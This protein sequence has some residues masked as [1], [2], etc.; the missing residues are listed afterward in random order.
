LEVNIIAQC[1]FIVDL[2]FDIVDYRLN[3]DRRVGLGT[4]WIEYSAASRSAVEIVIE[5]VALLLIPFYTVIERLDLFVGVV[6]SAIFF[7][8]FG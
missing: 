5:D 8:G 6:H 4:R 2:L 3:Y 1:I 7:I